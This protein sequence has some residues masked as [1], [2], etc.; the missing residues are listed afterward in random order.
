MIHVVWYGLWGLLGTIL[1]LLGA[2]TYV[3]RHHDWY[4]PHRPGPGTK[5]EERDGRS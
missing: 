2:H 1:F 5:E 4:G 3:H